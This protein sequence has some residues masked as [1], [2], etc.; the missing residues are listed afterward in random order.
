MHAVCCFGMARAPRLAQLSHTR[1]IISSV[2]G[3][4]RLRRLEDE[5]NRLPGEPA[6][7]FVKSSEARHVAV[8]TRGHAATRPP[9]AEHTAR[10]PVT[11][12]CLLAICGRAPRPEAAA[13]SAAPWPT[14]RR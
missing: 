6:D 11:T 2:M 1:P 3:L 4:K 7:Q 13:Q 8:L 10:S 14:L 12:G 9:T 5:A